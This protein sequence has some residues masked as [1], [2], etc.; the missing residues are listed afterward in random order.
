MD[1]NYTHMTIVVDRSGSMDFIRS[2]S[3]GGINQL[4]KDQ[5]L[6]PGKFTF[7]LVEF[8]DSI[9][10]VYDMVPIAD[11]EKYSLVPRGMTALYDAIGS[12]I[13]RTGEAL[14]KMAEVD[15]PSNVIFVI[16]T[17][18][19][20]NSS[21]EYSITKIKNLITEQT[22]KYNWDFTF[23]GANIDA[24]SVGT[25]IGIKNSVQY[26]ATASSTKS[27]YGGL[28]TN[29]SR[30]RAAGGMVAAG[31]DSDYSNA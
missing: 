6:E 13:V 11:V 27:V 9:D 18:G 17:D 21:R 8:D 29:T 25:S 10:V 28:T 15:R 23:I 14:T 12:G 16:V 1:T 24:F 2:D 20:E 26:A 19:G 22:D 31:M 3:E 5:K 4:I 7:S 30:V